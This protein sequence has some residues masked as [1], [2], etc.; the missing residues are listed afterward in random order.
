METSNILKTMSGSPS[1]P[2]HVQCHC[3]RCDEQ[4]ALSAPAKPPIKKLNQHSG[5]LRPTCHCSNETPSFYP[6]SNSL[7]T[8]L[9][10]HKGHLIALVDERL[11]LLGWIYRILARDT[12]TFEQTEYRISL[13]EMHRMYMR[14]LQIELANMGVAME[15]DVNTNATEKL[16][17]ELGDRKEHA[18]RNFA[19]AL[20]QYSRK[21]FPTSEST[22]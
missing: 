18:Q 17:K 22:G 19:P 16:K 11:P 10:Q 15:F 3:C 1:V 13:A 4:P 14:A 20:R 6:D 8:A 7:E 21:M 5:V 9:E 2:V 12:P